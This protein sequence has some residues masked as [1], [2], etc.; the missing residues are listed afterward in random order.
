MATRTFTFTD[1]YGNR[2]VFV[3]NAI[4]RIVENSR[5]NTITIELISGKAV[6]L[7][8]NSAESRDAMILK[9]ITAMNA[10]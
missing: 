7:T 2:T 3:I 10:D 6:T 9:M 8:Y 1:D 4:V 5:D